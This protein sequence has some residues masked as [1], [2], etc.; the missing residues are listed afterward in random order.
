MDS[1]KVENETIRNYLEKEKKEKN[2]MTSLTV[3]LNMSLS[4]PPLTNMVVI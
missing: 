2:S 3:T 4:S 1:A